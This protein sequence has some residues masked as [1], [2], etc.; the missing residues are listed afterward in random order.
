MPWCIPTDSPPLLSLL[1]LDVFSAVEFSPAAGQWLTWLLLQS[2]N[3]TDLRIL[4]C[5]SLVIP[6]LS[7]LLHLNLK[8]MDFSPAETDPL[9]HL[10]QL[11]TLRLSTVYDEQLQGT[12]DLTSLQLLERLSLED[13]RLSVLCR[14]G[15]LVHVT[16]SL[17]IFQRYVHMESGI[18]AVSVHDDLDVHHHGSVEPPP[19]VLKS[20]CRVLQWGFLG[21]LGGPGFFFNFVESRFCNLQELYLDGGEISI[22]LPNS[23]P[24]RVLH[25]NALTFWLTCDDVNKLAHM[26]EEMSIVVNGH[27]GFNSCVVSLSSCLGRLGKCITAGTTVAGRIAMSLAGG[28]LAGEQSLWPCKCGACS[29]CLPNIMKC[30]ASVL[31]D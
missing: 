10:S 26:L 11:K 13:I 22:H 27:V 23:I 9:R 17:P 4:C 30:A 7:S 16:A 24:L 18:Y 31:Y 5:R 21:N 2:T 29:V 8:C 28:R 19:L 14:D 1:R 20:G 15:C 6:P 25:V 3:L 12:L